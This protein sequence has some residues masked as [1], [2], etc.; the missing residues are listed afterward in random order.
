MICFDTYRLITGIFG[1][2][3]AVVGAILYFFR[4]LIGGI[5]AVIYTIIIEL[6]NA[7]PNNNHNADLQ[8]DS[9]GE[10]SSLG[11]RMLQ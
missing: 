7:L 8:Q 10:E 6:N 5:D 2:G 11:E 4:V 1:C 3:W 9:T